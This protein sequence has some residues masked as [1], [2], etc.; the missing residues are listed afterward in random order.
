MK[1]K[2]IC[3]KTEFLNLKVPLPLG[4]LDIVVSRLVSNCWIFS[5]D[6]PVYLQLVNLLLPSSINELSIR[7]KPTEFW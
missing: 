3:T 7:P 1:E 5:D 6:I 2:T 4:K